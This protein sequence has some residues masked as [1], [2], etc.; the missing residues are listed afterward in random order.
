M[1]WMKLERVARETQVPIEQVELQVEDRPHVAVCPTRLMAQLVLLHTLCTL[2][3]L[4]IVLCS[5]ATQIRFRSAQLST[6]GSTQMLSC[7][8]LRLETSGKTIVRSL[9]A[10]AI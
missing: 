2:T 3:N 1:L 6:T 5:L 10:N 9:G 4:Q 7:A 8:S